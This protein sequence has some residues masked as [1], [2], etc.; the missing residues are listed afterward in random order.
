[1]TIE[2]LSL[3]KREP[4]LKV[5][6]MTTPSLKSSNQQVQTQLCINGADVKRLP[7]RRD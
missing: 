3:W 2:S 6:Q 4:N 7:G 5:F 1:M